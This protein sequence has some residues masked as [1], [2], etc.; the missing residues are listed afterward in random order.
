MVADSAALCVLCPTG[1]PPWLAV[2]PRPP[3]ISPSPSPPSRRTG[4]TPSHTPG[5][6]SGICRPDQCSRLCCVPVPPTVPVR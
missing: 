4:D 6:T 1:C 3:S 5:Q 2:T